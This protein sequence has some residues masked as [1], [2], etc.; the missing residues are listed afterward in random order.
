MQTAWAQMQLVTCGPPGLADGWLQIVYKIHRRAKSTPVGMWSWCFSP[1]LWEVSILARRG[2]PRA[3]FESS[4]WFPSFSFDFS[5]LLTHFDCR[6]S[7]LWVHWSMPAARHTV[8]PPSLT[9]YLLSAVQTPRLFLARAAGQLAT[10]SCG[11]LF[12]RI[13][14]ALPR[15]CWTGWVCASQPARLLPSWEAAGEA[16]ALYCSWYDI[17]S[18]YKR[19]WTNFWCTACDRWCVS[20]ILSRVLCF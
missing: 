11:T 2:P 12:S 13:P 15:G 18:Q 9:A 16:K 17:Y 7:L 8:S 1:W 3:A 10:S 20:M 6:L 4:F 19:N 5:N 14:H